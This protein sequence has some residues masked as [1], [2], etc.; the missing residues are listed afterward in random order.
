MTSLFRFDLAVFREIHVGWHSSWLDPFFWAF[1]YSA[2]AQVPIIVAL[3]F[4][5]KEETRRLVWPLIASV[6]ISG[7]PVAQGIKALV[8]RDRPSNLAIATAQEDLHHSSF[9]SGHTTIAF[10]FAVTLFLFTRRTKLEWMGWAALAWAP[11]VGV[12][13]IYRGVHWPTDTLA[14]A[15]AGIF[16][17]CLV[18]LI[19]Q[20]W[21]PG[22]EASHE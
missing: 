5:L 15:C 17:G 16:S 6:A 13:R 10:A 18:Y 3:L 14:G 2:I 4:W 12:S 19:W 1:S 9:P 22:Q 20:R 21:N 8:P 11:L 7:L